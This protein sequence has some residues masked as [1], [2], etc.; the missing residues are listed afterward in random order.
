MKIGLFSDTYLPNINGVVTSVEM[1]RE[2]LEEM[3]HEVYVVCSHPG[4][5]HIKQEGRIISLP[6]VELKKLYGYS[7]AHPIHPLL[8]EKIRELHLDII[9]CHTE[10]GV[11]IFGVQIAKLFHIPLVKTYHTTYEDYTHYLNPLE[12]EALDHGLKYAINKISKFSGNDC[13][14]LISPSIKTKELL[15]SYGINTPIDVIPTGIE[16]KRFITPFPDKDVLEKAKQELNKNDNKMTFLYVGRIAQ[17][18]SIDMLMDC[19]KLVKKNNLNAKLCI[20]GKGPQADHLVKEINDND[21]KDT[22]YFL[23]SKPNSEIAAYYQCADAFVSASTSE[24]QGLT[25]IE[26][27]SSGLLVLGRYDEVVKEIISENE[28]G[29]LFDSAEELFEKIKTILDLP[30][31][32]YT[33]MKA[34]AVLSSKEY[35]SETFVNKIIETYNKAIEDY[36]N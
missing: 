35:N 3:G 14:R 33:T 6:G 12:F 13:T 2:K 24:T 15:L 10:F 7:L 36:K 8:M 5:L 30:E 27:L 29:Y 31:V 9:H 34:K 1:T 22:V 21:L 4:L 19:F 16:L 32:L 20:I 11:G 23:G 17:E 26:A 18:K 25:Y 28:N